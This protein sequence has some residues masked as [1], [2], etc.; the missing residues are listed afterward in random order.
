VATSRVIRLL[1]V[2]GP[3]IA[4]AATGVGAG[5]FIASTNAGAR[6]GELLLWAAVYGAVLKFAVN[7]GVAR[8]QLATGTTMLEGW[9]ERFG[10]PL[11]Y[12]FLVYLV[13]WSYF[14]G[15]GLISA[16]G[17][18]GHALFPQLSI[19]EW[20]VIHSLAGLAVVWFGGYPMFERAMKWMAAL[21]FAA[22]IVSALALGPS[23][24]AIAKGVVLPKVPSGSVPSILSVLGGIGGSL[25]ILCYGYWIREVG[26]SDASW[27]RDIRIDLA[28]AYVLTALFGVAVNVIGAQIKPEAAGSAAILTSMGDQMEAALGPLGRYTLYLGFWGAVATSLLGVWQ[29]IPY[30]FADF[31]ALVRR[32]QGP[33]RD[34]LVAQTSPW[35]RGFL[36]FLALPT[37]LAL[38]LE[39]PVSLVLVYT[40]IGALFMPLLAATL[41]YMNTRRDWLG[42]LR[43][44]WLSNAILVLALALFAYLSVVEV[45]RFIEQNWP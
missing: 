13:I 22:F 38:L 45:R 9:V 6:Y 28:C 3:G 19:S 32:A 42:E 23:L 18:A 33:A 2:L 44:G 14:V 39:Q 7:E 40:V 4:I 37:Q 11:Q 36:L 16:C 41:L 5:D 26:R 20:G 43:S 30:M 24:P 21:M 12:F 15:S 35:Y 27:L 31:V 8:W 34:A 29:G 25:T 1:S 10:R 17:L